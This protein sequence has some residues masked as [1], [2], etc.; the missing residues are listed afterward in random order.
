MVFLL[1]LAGTVLWPTLVSG[2][3]P[4]ERQKIDE[5]ESRLRENPDQFS[6]QLH[7]ELR[8]LYSGTDE[9]RSFQ[10]SDEIL[11]HMPM[12]GYILAIL[13]EWKTDNAPDEAIRTL[14]KNAGKY[15]E[16]PHLTVA[17]LLQA[18]ILSARRGREEQAKD[19]FQRALDACSPDMTAYLNLATAHLNSGPARPDD[20]PWTIRVVSIRYFPLTADGRRTDLSVTSNVDL[21]LEEVRAKCDRLDGE[22]KEALEQGSRFRAYCFPNAPKSLVYEIIDTVEVDEAMPH[23]PQKP[24]F[25]DYLEILTRNNIQRYIEEQGVKEVWLW[26]Y[27]SPSLAPWE[28]NMASPWGDV[29]N[30]DRDPSDL[31]VFA[32][33]YTVYHYNYQREA[34]EATEDHM[35]QIEAL[36]HQHG[37]G[38]FRLFTGEKGNWRSGNCHYPPNGESDYDWTNP[39]TVLSD[40]EDWRPDGPGK[41]KPLDCRTWDANSLKWFIYWMQ[42]L[43]GAANRLTWKGRPLSNWWRLVGDY[44]A[45]AMTPEP[46]VR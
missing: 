10:H 23:N 25:P 16:L 32:K 13:A 44:D 42:S 43:P 40:I 26:G 33:T 34:S 41:K 6:Y 36:L 24:G 18:G 29:S 5:L 31:P 46:L 11:K 21:S 22:V 20:V 7:N 8:H 38:L 28:S 15:R 3:Q 27:H 1:L 35:H 45:I 9:A 4:A 37:S 2:L 12:E 39:R 19:F 30:S 14:E 17:C